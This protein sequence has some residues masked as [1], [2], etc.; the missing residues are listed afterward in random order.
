[1]AEK[2]TKEWFELQDIRRHNF[3]QDEWILVYAIEREGKGELRKVGYEYQYSIFSSVLIFH[4]KRKKYLEQFSH[5]SNEK[6]ALRDIVNAKVKVSSQGDYRQADIYY[7]DNGEVLGLKLVMIPAKGPDHL[8]QPIIHQDFIVAYDLKE[9]S[10]DTWFISD[11]YTGDFAAGEE[12]VIRISRARGKVSRIE[13]KAIYLKDYLA[14]RDAGLR[15]GYYIS[16]DAIV[17]KSLRYWPDEK[18]GI[19]HRELKE[20][21]SIFELSLS[22]EGGVCHYM[23][24]L[25]RCEWVERAEYTRLME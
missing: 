10:R 23:G 3:S 12:D 8:R 13:I 24:E 25:H 14:A 19:F 2:L 21:E 18:L 9:S 11:Y 22:K 6:N 15:L 17:G 5:P 16:R 1:M 20:G 4:G 7:A